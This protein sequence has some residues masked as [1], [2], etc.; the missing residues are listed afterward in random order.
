MA[1]E[2]VDLPIENGDYPLFF[3]CLPAGNMLVI[4][5]MPMSGLQLSGG[6]ATVPSGNLIWQENHGKPTINLI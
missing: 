6:S 1:I 3:V 5:K 2:I 4:L